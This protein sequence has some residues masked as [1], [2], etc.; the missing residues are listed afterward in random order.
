MLTLTPINLMYILLTIPFLS[1]TRAV[2]ND[3]DIV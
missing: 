2:T 1:L 3:E